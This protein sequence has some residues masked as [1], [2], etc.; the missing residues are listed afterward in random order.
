MKIYINRQ[1]LFKEIDYPDRYRKNNLFKTVLVIFGVIFSFLILVK[2]FE[3]NIFQQKVSYIMI[4]CFHALIPSL[5]LYFYFTGFNYLQAKNHQNENWS[6]A[7]EYT[8]ISIVLLLTGVCSFLIRDIIY[9]N[10]NNWTWNYLWEEVRNCFVGGVILYFFM[11]L[12]VFYFESKKDSSLI[13]QFTPLNPKIEENTTSTLVY[14]K[15]QVKQDDFSLDVKNLLF[16]KADGNY[17]EITS[18]NNNQLNIELKRISLTQFEAQVLEVQNLF[19]CHRAYLVNMNHIKNMTGN[20][21]G[22]QLSFGPTTDKVPVSRSQ[23]VAF[24]KRYQEL[25]SP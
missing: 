3:V 12:A 1:H 17:I 9:L 7:K 13:F 6:L 5:I 16:V 2:P 19:R 24:N 15:T 10:S 20:S 11:R 8:H 25:L 14:I 18:C 23:L 4:C 22:Y 21:Q